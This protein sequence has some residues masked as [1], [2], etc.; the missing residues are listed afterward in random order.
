MA[1]GDSPVNNIAERALIDYLDGLLHDDDLTAEPVAEPVREPIPIA[2][3]NVRPFAEARAARP[4]RVVEALQTFT[5]PRPFAEPT[6]PLRMP[7]PPIAPVEVLAEAPVQVPLEAPVAAPVEMPTPVVRA[8]AVE[9]PP[10]VAPAPLEVP[11]VAEVETPAPPRWAANGRPQWAQQP[12]ECLLF[13]SGGLTLAVPLVELGSIYP[14]E[15]GDIS[16]IFGQIEWFL[17]LMR[18]KTNNLRVV[19]TARV[20][21]PER[22][23][24]DMTAGYR[25]VLSLSNSDWAL[26]I[27]AIDGTTLLDPDAVRWRSSDRSKR[28][29]LAGTVVEKMCALLDVAQLRWMFDQLDRKRRIR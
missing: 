24:D 16:E 27:D 12:F 20:V 22:Y 6:R 11:V 13:K 9:S 19:D 29:W 3:D 15:E 21:M 14:L 23:R 4:V 25:F 18:T 26:G 1:M 7:L 10:P 5:E 2:A 8:P 17:G 28:P